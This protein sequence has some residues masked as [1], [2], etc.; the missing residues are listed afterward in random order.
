MSSQSAVERFEKAA[1]SGSGRA[2]RFVSRFATVRKTWVQMR[3]LSTE[4]PIN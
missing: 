4:A 1:S 2:A 3:S